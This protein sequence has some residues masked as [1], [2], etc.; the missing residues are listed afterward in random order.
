MGYA[1]IGGAWNGSQREGKSEG[2]GDRTVGMLR[3][4]LWMGVYN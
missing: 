4:S 2:A 1:S 3:N